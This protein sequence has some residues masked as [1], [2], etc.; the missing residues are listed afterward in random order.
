MA[1]R[2]TESEVGCLSQLVTR[3]WRI[4]AE[5]VI[6]MIEED[7]MDADVAIDPAFLQKMGK[8]VLDNGILAAP[9]ADAEGSALHDRLA[10]LKKKQS[11]NLLDFKAEAR[12]RGLG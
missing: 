6:A 3:M 11:G 9:D 1:K 4:K 2:T 5:R 10:A 7:G 8:W 12:E